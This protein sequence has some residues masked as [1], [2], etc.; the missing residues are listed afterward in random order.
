MQRTQAQSR[1]HEVSMSEVEAC[2]SVSGA[3]LTPNFDFESRRASPDG[4]NTT[5]YATGARYYTSMLLHVRGDSEL[6]EQASC[7]LAK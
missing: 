5:S 4:S 1:N 7:R 6:K 3:N 2:R